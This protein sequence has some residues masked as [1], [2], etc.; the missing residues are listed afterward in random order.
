MADKEQPIQY[1][2]RRNMAGK[3]NLTDIAACIGLGQLPHLS[4]FTARR[5]A[6]ARRYF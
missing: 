6:L 4:D 1:S 2:D 3:H 5:H